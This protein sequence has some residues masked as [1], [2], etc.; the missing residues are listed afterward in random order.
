MYKQ[1][2]SLGRQVSRYVKPNLDRIIA[3]AGDSG[4]NVWFLGRDCMA[5]FSAY[6]K[7]APN[8]RYLQGLNR[9]CSRKLQHRS[10]LHTYLRECGVRDGD[11]L[12]DSGFRGSIFDRIEEERWSKDSLLLQ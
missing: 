12:I 10:V 1:G 2:R 11:I 9:E 6:K 7:V 8:V 5:L 4:V 3:R